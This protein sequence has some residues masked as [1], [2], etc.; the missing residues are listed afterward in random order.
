MSDLLSASSI[1]LAI[2]TAL[3]GI[4]Y[5]SI[6]EVLETRP[7]NHPEDDITNYNNALKIRKTKI[8]PLLISSISLTLIFIPDAYSIIKESITLI[9]NFGIT[10]VS[11]DTLKTTYIA[12]TIFM[13]ILTSNILSTLIKFNIHLSKINPKRKNI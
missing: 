13:I 7:N 11:Y 4:F 10:K 6:N 8:Y 1:I 12:V 3:Y 5:P 2:L 9:I